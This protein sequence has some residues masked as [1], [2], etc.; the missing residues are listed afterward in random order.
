MRRAHKGRQKKG[1]KK[2][3]E[4]QA[5]APRSGAKNKEGRGGANVNPRERGRNLRAA[6][7]GDGPRRVDSSSSRLARFFLVSLR[8]RR[9]APNGADLSSFMEKVGRGEGGVTG[10]GRFDLRAG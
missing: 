9:D 6:L 1:E 8:P 4:E 2:N 7:I 10:A 5:G 3:R